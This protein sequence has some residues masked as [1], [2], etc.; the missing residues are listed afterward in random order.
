M[1]LSKISFHKAQDKINFII[2]TTIM[3]YSLALVLLFANYSMKWHKTLH[4]L[5][6]T[7]LVTTILSSNKLLRHIEKVNEQYICSMSSNPTLRSDL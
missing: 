2:S 6:W 3:L 5:A 7:I 1:V 4:N